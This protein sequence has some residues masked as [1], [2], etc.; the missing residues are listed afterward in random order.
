MGSLQFPNMGM[1]LR[2]AA[3]G[4]RSSAINAGA[5]PIMDLYPKQQGKR[6][7][8]SHFMLQKQ[9]IKYKH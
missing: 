6:K 5:K 3:F 1:G 2:L 4:R 7:T 8:P 9:E